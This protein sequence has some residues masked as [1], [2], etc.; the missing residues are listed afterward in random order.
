MTLFLNTF[1]PHVSKL[2]VAQL[3]CIA[4]CWD[5]GCKCHAR[6]SLDNDDIRTK[7]VLQAD[8]DKIYIGAEIE[9]YFVYSSYFTNLWAIL[10]YSGSMPVLYP[11]AV[12]NFFLLYWFYK[13]LLIKSYQKTTAFNQELPMFSII[14]FRIGLLFHIFFTL[15]M[16]TYSK[17]IRLDLG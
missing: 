4:R 12:L 1:T 15:F 17:L 6:K 13:I 3:G 2:V 9:G 7:Q 8:L 11:I 5:R 16:Y 14:L 10:A